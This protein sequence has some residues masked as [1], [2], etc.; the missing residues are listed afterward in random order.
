M[1]VIDPHASL[2]ND[3][4]GIGKVLDFSTRQNSTY[5]FANNKNDVVSSTE[6]LL[7]LFKILIAEQYNSKLERVLR[8]SVYLLLT[9]EAFN[10][11]N[12]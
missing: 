8:H 7:D 9:Y 6:L 4:G 5:L 2:K 11:E 1:V 3:I 12:L 10:F